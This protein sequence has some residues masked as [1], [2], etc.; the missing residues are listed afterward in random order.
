MHDWRNSREV[1]L[2]KYSNTIQDTC[3][4]RSIHKKANTNMYNYIKIQ[5]HT[6]YRA[7]EK[8]TAEFS[9]G[10]EAAARLTG[11]SHQLIDQQTEIAVIVIP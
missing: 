6:L 2:N 9:P 11:R 8:S 3:K 4:Y 7:G 5:I 10:V 1:Q